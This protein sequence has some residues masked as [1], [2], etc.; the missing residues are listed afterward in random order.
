MSGLLFQTN[1]C[2]HTLFCFNQVVV[3]TGASHSDHHPAQGAKDITLNPGVVL[4][5][6]AL[7]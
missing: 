4:K 7:D 2:T 5:P 1:F 6:N 3:Y